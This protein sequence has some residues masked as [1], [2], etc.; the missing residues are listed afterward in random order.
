M[1]VIILF[2]LASMTECGLIENRELT[3]ELK[4]CRENKRELNE[5][6]IL[7]EDSNIKLKT[8]LEEL[9]TE[10]ERLAKE[11]PHNS[12]FE[13]LLRKIRNVEKDQKDSEK[14]LTDHFGNTGCQVFRWNSF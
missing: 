3:S 4:S 7:T 9:A 13:N 12:D 2:L 6:L 8:K 5:K 14:S 1:L 11:S 10:I